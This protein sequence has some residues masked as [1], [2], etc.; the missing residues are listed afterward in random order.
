MS[1]RERWVAAPPEAVWELLADGWSYADFVVGSAHV[2]R[3]DPGWPR[4]GT[5]LHPVVGAWPLLR[6]GST[7]SEEAD[8]P[9]R[10][11]LTARSWPLGGARVVFDLVPRDGGTL[12][13]LTEDAVEGPG[14]LVP[15]LLRTPLIGAR[16]T[17]TL[18]RLEALVVGRSASGRG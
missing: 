11:V 13:R 4:P 5:R 18:S 16:N 10:L 1:V 14:R 3:V 8:A 2:R 7:T 17:E 12:V 15:R 9:H 6:R